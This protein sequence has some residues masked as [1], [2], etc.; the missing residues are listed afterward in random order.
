MTQFLPWATMEK[1]FVPLRT[2]YPMALKMGP[3][4]QETGTTGAR[5]HILK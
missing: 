1:V 4:G 2:I 5:L 3:L